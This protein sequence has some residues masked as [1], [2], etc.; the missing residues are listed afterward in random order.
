MHLFLLLLFVLMVLLLFNPSLNNNIAFSQK[1]KLSILSLPTLLSISQP[2]PPTKTAI[3]N[4][5]NTN[6]NSSTHTLTQTNNDTQSTITITKLLANNLENRLQKAGS[7]LEITSKLPQVNNTWFA[8]LLN[9]TLTTLHGLPKEADIQKRQLAENILSD[10]K[11]FQIIV[12]LMPNG[13]IY[14]DE[15][16]SRQL[17]STT[18]NLAFRDYFQGAVKT[19]STYLGDV[20]T[21]AS[22]GQRQ[23]LIAVPIYSQKNNSTLIG[24]WAG[25]IDFGIL[26]KELQS[27][28]LPPGERVVYIDH[29][30]QK[31]ADSNTTNSNQVESFAHLQSFQNAIN[32]QSGLLVESTDGTTNNKMLV[33]YSPVKA[34][35]NTWVVLLTQP[36][37]KDIQR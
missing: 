27:L 35:Q 36:Y 22:S 34:F 8:H 6:N 9:Q 11:D 10:Y 20:I 1:P 26:N 24:V 19:H 30:G 18:S 32:G 23:A 33:T 3:I 15:P 13:D 29:K 21:S 2:P 28:K 4:N 17:A 12:F 7:V 31:L 25:G 5:S 37:T 14:M 16:Y